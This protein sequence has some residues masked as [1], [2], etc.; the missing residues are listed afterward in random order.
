MRK[1]HLKQA[2]LSTVCIVAVAV[3][4]LAGIRSQVMADASAE[5]GAALVKEHGC[6]NCH[7]LDSQKTK[8]GPGLKGLFELERLPVSGRPVTAQNVRE[9]LISPYDQMPSFEDKLTD[10][11]I[12]SIIKYLKAL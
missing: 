7:F 2:T 11:Q 10:E 8:F 5:Q 9:Q 6:T 3:I 4:A 1:I 12:Q